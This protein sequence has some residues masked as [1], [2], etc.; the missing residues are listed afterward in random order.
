[1]L[2]EHP[3]SHSKLPLQGLGWWRTTFVNDMDRWILWASSRERVWKGRR[4]RSSRGKVVVNLIKL[5]LG[6][7]LLLLL[8]FCWVL[9][10]PKL[11]K[12]FHHLWEWN[13]TFWFTTN[14]RLLFT[15]S[16]SNAH[17]P[18]RQQTTSHKLQAGREAGGLCREEVELESPPPP[19]SGSYFT[20]FGHCSL[21]N[22]C[23]WVEAKRGWVRRRCPYSLSQEEEEE[24]AF[25]HTG[26]TCPLRSFW[27]CN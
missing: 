5:F 1:M 17:P 19:W 11:G 27:L 3:R 8:I 14:T 18:D 13:I 7:M 22:G 6:I 23:E 20:R 26:E 24:F 2:R 10:G 12:Q 9:V 4:R 16:Y 25:V 15:G 21:I